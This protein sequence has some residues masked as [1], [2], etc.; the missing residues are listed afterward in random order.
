[1]LKNSLSNL[2]INFEVD[3]LKFIFPHQFARK[4]TLFYKGITPDIKYYKDI[5]LENYNNIYSKDWSFKVEC[6]KC[7]KADLVSLYQ[8][9]AKVNKQ[10]FEDYNV[11]ITDKITISG[12]AVDI[13]M[14]KYYNNIPFI[15]KKSM[16]KDIKDAYSGG[17]TEVYKPYGENIYYYDVNSLYPYVALQGMPGL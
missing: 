14:K 12:L 9:L 2:A 13:F 15:T 3:T 7:L 8:V 5:S 10:I 16:Y 6:I 11:N 1:M 4:N 17:I